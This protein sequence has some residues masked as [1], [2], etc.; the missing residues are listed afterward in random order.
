[1]ME[2][3]WKIVCW[4]ACAKL[5]KYPRTLK[6]IAKRCCSDNQQIGTN[7]FTFPCLSEF[8]DQ[9]QKVGVKVDAEQDHKDR[10]NDLTIAWNSLQCCRF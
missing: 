8:T 9:D 2:A 10:D 7:F 6:V 4:N 5:L 1:M 3:T